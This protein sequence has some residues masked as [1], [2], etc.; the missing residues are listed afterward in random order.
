MY[1][2]NN[3]EVAILLSVYNGS[4]YIIEQI[5]SIL[6]QTYKNWKLYVRD[7]GSQDGTIKLIKNTIKDDR[8][9]LIEDKEIHRGVKNSFLYLLKNT[10]ADY[11][12]FC[13]QDDVWLSK[14]IEE[15]VTMLNSIPQSIPGLV[16]CDLQLVNENLDIINESMWETH[17]L[18]KLVDN[19]NGLYIA[20][21][22]PG[23]TMA[24]NQVAKKLILAETYKF[25]L[26]DKQVAMVIKKN[27]GIIIPIHKP[28]IKYRLH[29]NNTVGL[30]SGK[31]ILINKMYTL[32]DVIRK[33]VHQMKMVH[34]YLKISKLTFLKLKF[35]HLFDII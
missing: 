15:S 31:H 20:S 8:I 19:K 32:S 18:Q 14:K 3:S 28:L 11:Y 7:D 10:Q 26:H 12:F 1:Q 17:R 24:F 16:C 22:F 25:D 30:Y 29:N 2:K 23:C 5:E 21:L 35:Q 27:N 34:D 6:A 33:N 4:K 9:V 13:D